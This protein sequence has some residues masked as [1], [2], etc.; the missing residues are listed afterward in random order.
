MN[1]I[2]DELYI[3]AE[4]AF[5]GLRSLG[6]DGAELNLS[7]GKM[8]ELNIDSGKF[9][10]LR[11]TFNASL[12]VR[13]L[14]GGRKGVAV[15]NSLEAGAVEAALAQAAESAKSS[16]PDDAEYI[17]EG[18]G[19]REFE[20]GGGECDLDGLYG[21]LD[22]FLEGC[23]DSF[24][25]I[26]PQQIISKHVSSG[27]LYANT[28]GSRV[29]TGS[30]CY[31]H[32]GEVCAR[33]GGRVSSMIGFGFRQARL[34]APFLANPQV[35]RILAETELQ[36]ETSP[37]DGKF[38]GAI[39]VAPDCF[40]DLLY[41]VV[42]NCV[43]DTPLIAGSSPWLG[44]LGEAVADSRLSVSFDPLDPRVVCG[45]R[46]TGDGHLTERQDV[47]KSGVLAG[48][49][50][51]QYGAKKTGLR[52]AGCAA[53]NFV[54]APG[55]QKFHGILGGIG[56]GLLMNRFSG[57]SPSQNGDFSGV[58]KNSFLIR[59]GEFAGAVSETM[60][61][62]NLLDMLQNVAGIG[63]EAVCDGNAAIPWAAFNGVTISGK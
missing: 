33:D 4:R 60:V 21:R 45:A 23:R 8:E 20:L 19:E 11:T 38:V 57:G 10:L 44:K 15:T 36:I 5:A 43:A 30:A 40:E 35:K 55:A 12:A 49:A 37:V 13:V 31:S 58:A 42:G 39:L 62:G 48:W 41:S 53:G 16:E 17:A 61:S 18:I 32:G 46:V 52:R 28:N 51:S 50:L 22:E 54:V 27:A 1:S 47:I 25:K 14:S 7:R 26:E 3:V 6:A 56:R 59:D 24:P 63:D 29:Y 9:S 2:K 34:D